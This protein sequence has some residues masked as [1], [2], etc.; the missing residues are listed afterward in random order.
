MK[1]KG[2]TLLITGGASGI[3]LALAQVFVEKGNTVLICGRSEEKLQSVKALHPTVHVYHADVSVEQSRRALF[4]RIKNDEH[5][6]DVLINNAGI[7]APQDLQHTE[8][9]AFEQ[10]RAEV[11]TNL[12]APIDFTEWFLKTALAKQEAAIINIGSPAGVIPIAQTPGYSLTKSALHSF[13]QTLR[14]QL[15]DTAV[16]VIEVF[17]PSVDTKMAEHS[18]R[19]KLGCVS[20][21]KKAIAKIEAGKSEVWVGEAYS[22]RVFAKLPRRF[23][24]NFINSMVPVKRAP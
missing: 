16:K 3:G 19:K 6:V 7:L 10:I 13:T 22:V 2:K 14:Y 5:D 9:Q 11:A 23:G 1:M 8:G 21:A 12:L 17:P 18:G 20:F 24:F 15:R 4:D